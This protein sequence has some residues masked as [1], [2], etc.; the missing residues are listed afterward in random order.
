[1]SLLV[2]QIS[3]GVYIVD[4]SNGFMPFILSRAVVD[5]S[6]G[7]YDVGYLF[8]LCWVDLMMG[9]ERLC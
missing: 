6:S 1:M 5:E 8:F 9:R 3:L 2:R 7:V 4:N